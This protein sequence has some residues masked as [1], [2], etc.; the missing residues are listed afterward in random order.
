MFYRKNAIL[1]KVLIIL[2]IIAAVL[3]TLPYIEGRLLPVV[4][5]VN[6]DVYQDNGDGWSVLKG[7][8]KKIRNCNFNRLEWRY[9]DNQSNVPVALVFPETVLRKTNKYIFDGWKLQLIPENV[10]NKSFAVVYHNCHPLWPTI[11]R[12]YP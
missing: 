11:T 10:K 1:A 12:F 3:P 2:M 4:T 5:D 7:S 9:G 8:F 6:I